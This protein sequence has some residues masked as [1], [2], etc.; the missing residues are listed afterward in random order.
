[1]TLT[2]PAHI[3]GSPQDEPVHLSWALDAE[4]EDRTV[5]GESP[6]RREKPMSRRRRGRPSHVHGG[7]C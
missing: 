1:V 4:D 3:P 2:G 5:V 7:P 6:E